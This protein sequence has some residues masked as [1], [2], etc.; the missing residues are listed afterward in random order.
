[1]AGNIRRSSKNSWTVAFGDRGSENSL[2]E[3]FYNFKDAKKFY[4][5]NQDW[6]GKTRGRPWT[7][8]V[9]HSSLR[10]LIRMEARRRKAGAAE[11]RGMNPKPIGRIKGVS[12]ELLDEATKIRTK[13]KIKKYS[14]LSGRPLDQVSAVEM[15]KRLKEGKGGKGPGVYERINTLLE[16]LLR[17]KKLLFLIP[18]EMCL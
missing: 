10:Q 17:R 1:M 4:D 16:K 12:T 2:Y 7:P 6:V 18:L 3:I 5:D 11:G 14:G 13:G 9:K 15:A 8:K